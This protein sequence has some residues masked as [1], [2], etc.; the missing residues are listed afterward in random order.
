MQIEPM[1]KQILK[2]R[3]LQKQFEQSL[4]NQSNN[5]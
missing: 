2:D 3:R 1:A 4:N 5:I